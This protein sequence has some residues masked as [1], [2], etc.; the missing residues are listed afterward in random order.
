MKQFLANAFTSLVTGIF[1]AIGLI[2]VGLAVSYF[3]DREPSS[4]DLKYIQ[5]PDGLRVIAHSVIPGRPTLTIRGAIENTSSN[6]W[7][8]ITVVAD[9]KASD[10]QVNQCE[11]DIRGPL[12]P[13][14]KRSFQI[15]CYNVSGSNLPANISYTLGI[16]VAGKEG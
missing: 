6:T 1:F 12:A 9:I 5:L 11:A 8:Q 2:L 16:S 14:E 4:P 7:Q 10:V 3:Y 15:N 13:R